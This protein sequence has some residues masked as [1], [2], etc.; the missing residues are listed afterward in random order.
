MFLVHRKLQA[1]K[2]IGLV[3]QTIS[4]FGLRVNQTISSSAATRYLP[5]CETQR[6][7][8]WLNKNWFTSKTK[9]LIRHSTLRLHISR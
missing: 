6:Y 2:D 9:I 7:T 5:D 8:N 3:A 1:L 4:A